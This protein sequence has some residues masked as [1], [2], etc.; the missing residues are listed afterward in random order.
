MLKLGIFQAGIFYPGTKED[1]LYGNA[2]ITTD[3]LFEIVPKA[4]QMGFTRF[5]LGEHYESDVA[6]RNPE[7]LLT[8]L[9]G[10][11]ERIRLGVAGVLLN[12][13]N[14]LLVA[15]NYNLLSYFFQN[16]ID[17]GIAKGFS[18]DEV[19]KHFTGDIFLQKKHTEYEEIFSNKLSVT[20]K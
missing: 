12:L 3:Q 11:T 10:C 19:M 5:W 17:L 4:E 14:P 13:H 1:P 15:Q 9:A 18:S 6:W 2:N 20:G 16:R 8:L 7:L